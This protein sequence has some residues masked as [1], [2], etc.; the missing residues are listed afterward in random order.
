M[1]LYAISDIHLSHEANRHAFAALEKRPRDWLI[2]AGD[3]GETNDH[4]EFAFRTAAACYNRVIWV[5][6]NHELWSLP[7]DTAKRGVARYEECVAV[8]RA[9]GVLTPEDPYVRWDGEGGPLILAPLF[10]LYDYTFRPDDVS[11]AGALDWARAS[12]IECTDEVLLYPDPYPTRDAWCE[13]RCAYTEAR[14]QEAA[15]TGVPLVLINHFTLRYDLVRIPRVPRF[16][17]W[18]GTKRTNDWHRRFNARVVV[19]GHLHVRAT[20]WVD[21]VRFEEVSLGYPRQ[22]QEGRDIN[23]YVREILPGPASPPGGTA[24]TEWR[25]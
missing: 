10:L 11:R 8:C 9:H 13:A 20:D 21:G 2:L 6:G 12:G 1:K 7:L 22:W 16:S 5:P 3:L 25:R 14:L 4:L 15:A 17:I 24:A 19:T 23:T 18:C